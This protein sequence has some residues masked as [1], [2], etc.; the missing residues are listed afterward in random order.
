MELK[1]KMPALIIIDV[2]SGFDDEAYWGGNRNNKNME[3]NIAEL[4]KNWRKLSWPVIHVK[5]NSV[6][7]GSPLF[8]GNAGN[9][10]KDE[11]RPMPGETVIAKDVNSAFIGTGLETLLKNNGITTL[12]IT[13]LQTDHCVS[14]TARMAANLSFETV[15]VSDGTATFDR[16]GV[17]GVLLNSDI[18]HNVNLASLSQEFATIADTASIIASIK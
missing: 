7:S 10:I 13:G 16:T 5:H 9:M 3:Y 6:N 2:Q 1:D 18:I 8:E 12:V 4:L 15:V 17:D 14:T 11:V